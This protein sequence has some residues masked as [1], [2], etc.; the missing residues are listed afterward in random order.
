MRC[1]DPDVSKKV[2]FDMHSSVC[3]GHHY[4]RTTAYK[5]LRASYFWPSL[6]TDVCAEVRTCE[7]Y[8]KFK[9]K[10]H[11]TSFPLKPIVVSA[12]FQQWG[13]DFIRE[14]H[15]PSSGKHCWILVATD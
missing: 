11:L 13:L 5:I 9:G 12:P 2:M 4:W 8:Q 7:K 3:G 1:I 6:F 10:K 14:I 15:P